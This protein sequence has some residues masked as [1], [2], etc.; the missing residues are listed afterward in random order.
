M[1]KHGP[2]VFTA[3]LQDCFVH[4]DGVAVDFEADVARALKKKGDENGEKRRIQR[5][6]T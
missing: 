3:D 5:L 4:P 1:L 2:V 6:V